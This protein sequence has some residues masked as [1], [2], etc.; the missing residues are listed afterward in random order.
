MSSQQ[1]VGQAG[2]PPIQGRPFYYTGK[3]INATSGSRTAN[4]T[5]L[6]PGDVLALDPFGHDQ[7]FGTDL[8]NP[9][10]G[11][12]DLP[13]FVVVGPVSIDSLLGG[14]IQA[15]PLAE[16]TSGITGVFHK[17]NA[18]AGVT[19]LGATDQASASVNQRYLVGVTGSNTND[20]AIVLNT[21][22]AVAGTTYDSSSTASRVNASS[23]ELR[24][25]PI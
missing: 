20:T 12:L 9:T 5:N 13:L 1:N 4:T 23:V 24:V 25:V 11:Y 7:G 14:W 22:K 19:L 17:V 8:A 10:T 3:N 18:T 15:V 21:I 16:C 6:Q 2:F